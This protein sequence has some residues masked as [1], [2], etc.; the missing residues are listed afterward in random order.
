MSA[1]LREMSG[2]V[3]LQELSAWVPLLEMLLSL[4]PTR[5]SQGVSARERVGNVGAEGSLH[6]AESDTQKNNYHTALLL[7]YR[8]LNR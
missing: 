8:F 3:L 1:L 2:S 5:Y 4:R 7:G 6:R